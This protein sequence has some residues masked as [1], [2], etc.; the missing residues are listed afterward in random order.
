V[1]S[2]FDWTRLWKLRVVCWFD[3]VGT[4]SFWV[5]GLFFGGRRYN[6]TEED[7]ASQSNFGLRELVEVDEELWSDDECTSRAKALLTKLKQ[8]AESLTLRTTV[9]DYANTPILPGETIHVTLP[10]ENVNGNFRVASAEYN[11][12][13]KTQTFE[14]ILEMGRETPMLADYVFALRSKLDHVSRYKTARR[15]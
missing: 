3:D 1:E 14:T 12:D 11:I 6:A 5:D 4:G 7:A 15:G 8:P 13:A 2:G 10:N 9:L